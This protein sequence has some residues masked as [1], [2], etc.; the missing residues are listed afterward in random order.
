MG[1]EQPQFYMN[2]ALKEAEK[3]RKEQNPNSK[4]KAT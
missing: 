1:F 3:I 4:N 2:E